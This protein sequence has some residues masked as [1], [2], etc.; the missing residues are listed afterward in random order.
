MQLNVHIKLIN[1]ISFIVICFKSFRLAALEDRNFQ[2]FLT[3]AETTLL[4]HRLDSGGEGII[5]DTIVQTIRDARKALEN[6]YLTREP[7]T[8]I[9]QLIQTLE[10]IVN[11]RMNCCLNR[12]GMQTFHKRYAYLSYSSIIYIKTGDKPDFF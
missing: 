2:Q 1:N 9:S 7:K 11:G 12:K 8:F 4:D 10:A 5:R 6:I 3:K